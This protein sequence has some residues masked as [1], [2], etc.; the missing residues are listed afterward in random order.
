M[1]VGAAFNLAQYRLHRQCDINEDLYLDYLEVLHLVTHR[2]L[3]GRHETAGVRDKLKME[4][5]V[6]TVYAGYLE[7]EASGFVKN[8]KST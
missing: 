5:N 8:W 2:K 6:T 7:K 3:L 1:L 4:H